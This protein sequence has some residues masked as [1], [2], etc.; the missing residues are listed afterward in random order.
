MSGTKHFDP[1]FSP[2][3]ATKSIHYW[4]WKGWNCLMKGHV[5][6]QRNSK[7]ICNLLV[8]GKSEKGQQ[9]YDKWAWVKT[10]PLNA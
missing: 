9:S 3:R 4:I 2:L 8:I 6:E 10:I 7:Y 5:Q 1:S